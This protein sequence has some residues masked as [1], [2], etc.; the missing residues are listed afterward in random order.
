[1]VRDRLLRVSA[2]S[3]LVV[4]DDH[5]LVALKVSHGS[6]PGS[7]AADKCGPASARPRRQ[8]QTVTRSSPAT[9]TGVSGR[10]QRI[11]ATAPGAGTL[12]GAEAQVMTAAKLKES[13]V[14]AVV[15][16]ALD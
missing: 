15:V 13:N 16:L 8:H 9:P 1:M 3:G 11:L 5:L 12:A 2:E 7:S 4:V 6:T 10:H 14:H